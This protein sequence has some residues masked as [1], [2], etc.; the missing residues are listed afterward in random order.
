MLTLPDWNGFED[1]SFNVRF[2]PREAPFQLIGLQV[3]L[4]DLDGNARNPG[5]DVAVFSSDD[6]GYPLEE[7]T[8]FEVPNRNLIL[9]PENNLE[10]NEISFA[11]YDVDP[12]EFEEA[13]DFHIVLNV[14]QGD[15]R[16]TLAVMLDDGR[17][18]PTDRSGFWNSEWEVWDLIEIVYELGYNFAIRAVVEYPDPEPP[19]IIIDPNAIEVDGP[20]EYPIRIINTG[21]EILE[22]RIEVVFNEEPEVPWIQC[23]PQEGELGAEEEVQ[24]MVTISDEGLVGGDHQ[25]ELHFF[26]NDPE[27]PEIVLSIA[28]EVI[29]VPVLEVNP[30]ELDFGIVDDPEPRN[31]IL[32]ISNT[33]TELLIIDEISVDN[34]FFSIDFGNALEI[35]IQDSTEVTVTFT[36]NVPG[37]HRGNIQISSNDPENNPVLIPVQ[38]IYVTPPAIFIDPLNIESVDGGEYDIIL[39]NEGSLLLEWS[40][41]VGVEWLT[42]EPSEGQNDPWEETTLHVTIDTTGLAPDNYQANIT[43]NSNDPVNPEVA[44]SVSLEVTELGVGN[45]SAIPLE[46]GINAIYPNPFNSTATIRFSLATRGNVTLQLFD[47]TG[48][49]VQNLIRRCNLEPGEHA[50]MLEGANLTAGIYTIRLQQNKN[51]QTQTINVIK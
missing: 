51:V 36:P 2:T 25:A 42:I 18:E 44:I 47:L 32:T 35:G 20:G 8:S 5:M 15:Q 1:H 46:F 24:V 40:T 10:W 11:D 27:N 30:V 21:E 3:V 16:D 31:E 49:I 33:G 23:E 7:I 19:V 39:T 43:F 26:S 45:Q 12:I 6:E 22:W 34:D 14:I 17:N 4:S 9:S 13:V 28:L 37:E 41:V 38:A 48:H 29:G 50:I